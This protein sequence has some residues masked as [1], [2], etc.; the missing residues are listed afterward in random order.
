M[1]PVSEAL[2]LSHLSHHALLCVL[3]PFGYYEGWATLNPPSVDR[4]DFHSQ[5]T[6]AHVNNMNY[7]VKRLSAEEH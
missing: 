6:P 2:L 7:G 3:G 4:T 5:Q 1:L